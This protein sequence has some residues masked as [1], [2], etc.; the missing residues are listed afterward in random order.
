M[1]PANESAFARIFCGAQDNFTA[2]PAALPQRSATTPNPAW[3]QPPITPPAAQTDFADA[4]SS[5][6][7]DV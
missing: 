2:G 7:G 5:S 6:E 3:G 4:G 1:D